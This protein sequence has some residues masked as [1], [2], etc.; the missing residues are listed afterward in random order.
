M[1][2]IDDLITLITKFGSDTLSESDETSIVIPKITIS[3]DVLVELFRKLSFEYN[4]CFD[5]GFYNIIGPYLRNNWDKLTDAHKDL[6]RS[7]ITEAASKNIP[8][9]ALNHFSTLC[10]GIFGLSESV[11]NDF[12]K[13]LFGDLANNNNELRSKI[14][15][16]F[17]PVADEE[18]LSQNT[19]KII[20][21]VYTLLQAVSPSSKA[22][23]LV[24]L[25]NVDTEKFLKLKPEL[26]GVLYNA[27]VDVI[28]EEPDLYE[29]V[30]SSMLSIIVNAPNESKRYSSIL[31][32]HI[33]NMNNYESIRVIL[34]LCPILDKEVLLVLIQKLVDN[35]NAYLSSNDKL[36][37]ELMAII[38]GSPIDNFSNECSEALAHYFVNNLDSNV[39]VH[40]IFAPLAAQVADVIGESKF[41]EITRKS[42]TSMDIKMIQ[43]G[44]KIL[45]CISE[46]FT[47]LSIK[48]HESSITLVFNLFIHGDSDVCSFALQCIRSFIQNKFKFSQSSYKIIFS[49]YDSIRPENKACFFKLI[50]DAFR[51]ESNSVAVL[52]PATNFVLERIKDE[53]NESMLSEYLS[54]IINIIDH[55]PERVSNS[56]EDILYISS[57]L[58]NSK[59]EKLYKYSSRALVSSLAF[60][61]DNIV[62]RQKEFL[63]RFRS[64]I[65]NNTYSEKTRSNV[66]TCFAT[67][68][69]S[70]KYDHEINYIIDIIKLFASTKETDF[71]ISACI[72]A[73]ML[74]ETGDRK[75]IEELCLHLVSVA[76]SIN[77]PEQ[78]NYLLQAINKMI[79]DFSIEFNIYKDLFDSLILGTNP[80]FGGRPQSMYNDKKTCIFEFFSVV[81]SVNE[82]LTQSTLD[83][84]IEWLSNT[85]IIM[86]S[87]ILVFLSEIQNM[88][89]ISEKSLNLLQ[90]VLFTR[91]GASKNEEIDS[92]ITG[93]LVRAILHSS[94][95]IDVNRYIAKFYLLWKGVLDDE[96]SQYRSNIALLILLMCSLKGDIEDEVITD[97]LSDFPFDPEFEVNNDVALC[98]IKMMESGE[99]SSIEP[100]VAKSFCDVLLKPD[101]AIVK[102]NIEKSTEAHMKNIVKGILLKNKAIEKEITKSF[103]KNRKLQN[104]FQ[105]LM[106]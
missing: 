64:I 11:W 34:R 82:S 58:I 52:T 40:C 98:L 91:V 26:L 85:T 42:L 71:M 57:K 18:Y 61:D 14:I 67:I 41:F 53:N 100:I 6:I 31:I 21:V 35:A 30:I 62:E 12:N 59:D 95:S 92:L 74:C 87:P 33:N 7:K 24:S 19:E 9:Q 77:I 73:E 96:P 38:E 17:I 27:T 48:I 106:K 32:E 90:E 36:P 44:I 37:L 25:G 83:A 88:G 20:N 78:M 56:I 72:I 84:V 45:H 5:A 10:V 39:S 50:R 69:I 93:V 51:D 105:K 103:N 76:K 79:E 3:S 22:S 102:L 1:S 43:S 46:Y 89:H 75:L 63:P 54:I 101:E 13:I 86:F 8:Q 4:S 47:N 66:A 68:C 70:E 65:E 15:A 80:V 94:N 81:I 97:I 16:K 2:E 23:I 28:R 60:D 29:N 99:W 104:R 49:H 55:D